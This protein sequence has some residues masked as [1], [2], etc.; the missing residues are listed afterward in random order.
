MRCRT[1]RV[2]VWDFGLSSGLWV[3]GFNYQDF[4]FTVFVEC[5]S[6]KS[7]TTLC[8]SHMF[9]GSELGAS[10]HRSRRFHVLETYIVLSIQNFPSKIRPVIRILF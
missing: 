7:T 9:V 4:G 3:S 8:F 2:S 10:L 5:L 1:V 6:C